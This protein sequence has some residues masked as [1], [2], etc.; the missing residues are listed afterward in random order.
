M[1]CALKSLKCW[2]LLF[3]LGMLQSH[4]C[5]TGPLNHQPAR[6]ESCSKCEGC[7]LTAAPIHAHHF[8]GACSRWPTPSADKSLDPLPAV[9]DSQLI[10]TKCYKCMVVIS[11]AWWF[12]VVSGWHHF[13]LVP[14]QGSTRW[15]SAS[16]L[17][18]LQR[19]WRS[20]KWPT[21]RCC[22]K[23][24]SMVVDASLYTWT[25]SSG[26]HKS[27]IS[28]VECRFG[29]F[30]LSRHECLHFSWWRRWYRAMFT[31]SC[32]LHSFYA[33]TLPLMQAMPFSKR[34]RKSWR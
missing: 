7:S 19:I 33:G 11:L 16:H 18:S 28:T 15:R 13:N 24:W 25:I 5:F 31:T 29:Y 23:N 3:P 22:E 14:F 21:R 2:L 32:L 8:K 4:E 9:G 12:L 20:T 6:V 27:D 1:T 30:G 26:A 10:V 34:P 17:G